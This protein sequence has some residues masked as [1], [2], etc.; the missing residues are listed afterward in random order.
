MSYIKK[1]WKVKD[2]Q[3][4]DQELVNSLNHMEQGIA[5]GGGG[6][7][8]YSA[9]DGI[10]IENNVISVNQTVAK[11]QEVIDE[12]NVR[13]TADNALQ[14]G[15]NQEEIARAEAD[16]TLQ[17]NITA[18]ET[19]AK[20][21]E[22]KKLEAYT[23][24]VNGGTATEYKG[25]A[26]VPV[27]FELVPGTDKVT[28]KSHAITLN[29]TKE[30]NAVVNSLDIN[31][32]TES[33]IG[34]M[35]ADDAKAVRTD[36]P[37]AISVE[38]SQRESE[39]AQLSTLIS[40]KQDK[41]TAGTNITINNNTISATDTTYTAGENITITNNVISAAGATRNF[42]D[43]WPIKG[44]CEEF[45]R[46]VGADSNA[47][48]GRT[49]Q[50][51]VEFSDLHD[52]LGLWNAE[53][54]VEIISSTLSTGYKIIRLNV[55]SATNEP[56]SWARIYWWQGSSTSSDYLKPWQITARAA[57]QYTKPI[58]TGTVNK[59]TGV[60]TISNW[61]PTNANK[62]MYLINIYGTQSTTQM[63]YTYYFAFGGYTDWMTCSCDSCGTN[64]SALNGTL[65]M[66]RND[67][68]A[69]G[70]DEDADIVIYKMR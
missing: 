53:A 48:V 57:D 65:T 29:T 59:A 2:F 25:P 54:E 61:A 43:T 69:L 23:V 16:V 11:K 3:K 14:E 56:Y 30:Q 5:E 44:T 32:A 67:G 24:T 10:S 26:N 64:V 15:I 51:G 1:E 4:G 39:Y 50:G 18:E 34:L 7:S 58:A 37:Q 12:A 66:T 9:G 70:W 62:G 60:A 20:A 36:L 52:D 40:G 8:S 35:T 68:Q 27:F 55:Y 45:L 22:A 31:A 47:V 63:S 6:G 49:Y 28:V 41:L 33:S 46:A 42:P 21:E 38:K 13:T 19:R 17:A